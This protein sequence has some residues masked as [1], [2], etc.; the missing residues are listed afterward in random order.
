MPT[1]RPVMVRV[2]IEALPNEGVLAE[3]ADNVGFWPNLGIAVRNPD[4]PLLAG[5]SNW[6]LGPQRLLVRQIGGH[7]LQGYCAERLKINVILNFGPKKTAPKG[8]SIR[9]RSMP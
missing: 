1:T 4:S 3:F 5:S 9:S 7:A 2:N 8:G 6:Y